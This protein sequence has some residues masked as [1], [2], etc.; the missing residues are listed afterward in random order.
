MVRGEV[1]YKPFGELA[2][3][4]A[5][6]GYYYHVVAQ[7]NLVFRADISA[8]MKPPSPYRVFGGA[9]TPYALIR[10]EN[11]VQ[12]G[13]NLGAE[14]SAGA[15]LRKAGRGFGVSLIYFNRLHNGYYF[16][17]YEKGAGA[18]YVFLF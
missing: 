4:G 6:F 7:K 5:G 10:V 16:E 13:N 2:E 15:L 14:V 11:V 12:A 17:K 8:L 18:E 3:F 1:Y 9:L